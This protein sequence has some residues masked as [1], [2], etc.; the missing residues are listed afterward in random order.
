MPMSSAEGKEWTK[1]RVHALAQDGP[2]TVLDIGPGVGTYAKL[3]AGPEVSHL[4]GLEIFEPYVHTSGSGSTTTTSSSA[5]PA[6]SSCLRPT[7]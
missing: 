1:E 4:T 6:R 3:L 7:W 2:V 5:T